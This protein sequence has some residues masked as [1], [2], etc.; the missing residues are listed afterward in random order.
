MP[1]PSHRSSGT[2][3]TILSK[4]A[5]EGRFLRQWAE[6]PLGIGAVAPSSDELAIK[7]AAELDPQTDGVFVE[8]GPGTGVVTTAILKRGVP[9]GRLTAVEYSDSFA[10]LLEQRF[11][12]VTVVQGDAYTLRALVGSAA[13]LA[14]VIS[15]LPLF[16]QPPE[17][18]RQLV[19]DA[20]GLLAPGAPLVQFSYALVPPVKPEPGNFT[21]SKSRWIWN[22][23]P[24]ARVW[25]YRKVH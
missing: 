7:M 25:V 1:I 13:P 21:V 18:R 8:L 11:P 6:N 3:R 10:A 16:S 15:S 9:A 19:L 24:P 17:K 12:G 5:D 22:N 2:H 20:L 23:V 14:G 4:M